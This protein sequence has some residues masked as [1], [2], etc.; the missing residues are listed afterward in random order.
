VV[1]KFQLAF[2]GLHTGVPEC[3]HIVK[4]CIVSIGKGE[5]VLV[6][7]FFNWAPHHGGI[8]GRGGTA[9]HTLDPSTS[10]RWRVSLILQLLYTQGMSPCYPLYR[11][12]DGTQSQSGRSG[13][14]K[15]SQPLPG[16]KPPINQHA[17]QHYT[18]ELSWLLLCRSTVIILLS[19]F[20]FTLVQ[21]V[22]L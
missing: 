21:R 20:P 22:T 13:E 8:L 16:L 10:W 1:H 17:A 12:L 11:R 19:P 9:P 15:T 4:I 18:T 14:D 3:Y 6:L 7:F 5:V 2:A